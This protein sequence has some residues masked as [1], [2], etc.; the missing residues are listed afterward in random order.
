MAGLGQLLEIVERHVA[1]IAPLS[2]VDAHCGVGTFTLPISRFVQSAIGLDLHSDS[3]LL[4]RKNMR[5]NRMRNVKFL[6]GNLAKLG[7]FEADLIVLNPPR[8]GCW[9]EDIEAL[10]SIDSPH[11]LYISCNPTTLA[12]DL[13]RL[14]ENY[15]VCSLDLVDLFPMTYHFETVVSV[16]CQIFLF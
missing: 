4:A 3:V 13:L 16:H 2:C 10:K 8:G 6:V 12:R 9:P 7:R 5:C 15:E 14:N 1:S 11:V